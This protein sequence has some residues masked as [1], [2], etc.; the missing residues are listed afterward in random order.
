MQV[1]VHASVH[2][3][4]YGCVHRGVDFD[5][6]AYVLV[7]VDVDVHVHWHTDAFNSAYVTPC[8]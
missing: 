6:D 3:K 8:M 2:P 1:L 4:V 7:D 5:A